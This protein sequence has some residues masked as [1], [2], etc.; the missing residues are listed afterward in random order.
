MKKLNSIISIAL[1]LL[2]VLS[3]PVTSFPE[4]PDT[5]APRSEF[6]DDSHKKKWRF[7]T[8]AET[9]KMVI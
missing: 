8:E 9:Q 1:S 5:L 6:A 7:L 3:T 4:L 2:L